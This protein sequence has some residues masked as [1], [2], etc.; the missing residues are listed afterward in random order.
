MRDVRRESAVVEAEWIDVVQK[1]HGCGTECG[2]GCA[3]F[4]LA[5]PAEF[6]TG[7]PA[8][9]ATFAACQANQV[10]GRSARG[11]FAEQAGGE[12][13]VIRMGEDGDDRAAS[14]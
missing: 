14:F 13:F 3:E 2:G 9:D 5:N 6:L 8:G 1:L 4:S 10:E 11:E 12:E 7:C